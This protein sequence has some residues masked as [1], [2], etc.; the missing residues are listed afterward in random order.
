MAIKNI[1]MNI[2]LY[3]LI[4][5]VVLTLVIYI[6]GA[7]LPLERVETR[8]SRYSA[9]PEVVYNVVTNNGDYAYRSNLKE[10]IIID[11]DQ[12]FEVWDEVAK[13]GSVIRFKTKEKTPYTF[14]SFDME[15]KLFTGYWT[16]EFHKTEDGGTLFIAS[17]HIRMKNPLLKIL[18]Y[19]FFDIGKFME[20]YQNDLG[21]KLERMK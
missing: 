2:L 6:I 11:K 18:S 15:S 5:I 9:P 7:L 16:A 3:I 17:E 19:L 14:Y 8:Q 4:G 21:K 20:T 13:D 1:N 12:D 10:I